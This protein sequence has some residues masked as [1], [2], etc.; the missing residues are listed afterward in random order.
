MASFGFSR[1]PQY[2]CQE[3]QTRARVVLL[4]KALIPPLS[5]MEPEGAE[6]GEDDPKSKPTYTEEYH[7]DGVSDFT[8]RAYLAIKDHIE[9]EYPGVV[10]NPQKYYIGIRKSRNLAYM[11]FREK[12]LRVV[13][14]L[15]EA[16]VRSLINE[17]LVKPMSQAN[18]DFYNGPSCF[19]IL[20]KEQDVGELLKLLKTLIK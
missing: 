10:L 9:K 1:L 13:V 18:Q 15:P 6:A 3:I 7:L 8:K 17:E 16:Q 4:P 12:K 11:K 20:Q 14:M 2:Y 19:V 5:A